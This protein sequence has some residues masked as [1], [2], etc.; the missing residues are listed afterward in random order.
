MKSPAV[1]LRHVILAALGRRL[2]S[3]VLPCNK[4]ITN[5]AGFDSKVVYFGLF[6]FLFCVI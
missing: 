4:R 6:L 5:G 3:S 1:K 2:F